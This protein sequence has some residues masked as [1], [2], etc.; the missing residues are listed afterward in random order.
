MK[1]KVSKL[2]PYAERLQEWFLG[3]KTLVEAQG[4]LGADGCSVSLGRL[5]EW[6]SSRQSWIQGEQLIQQITSGANQ[7]REVEAA[8]GAHPAPE[9]ETVIKL[10]R[11]LAMQFATRANVD[12]KMMEQAERATKM[13]LEFAKLLEKRRVTDLDERRVKLLEQK[14]ALADAATGVMGDKALSEEQRAARMR[15]LFGMCG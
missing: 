9:L 7:C 5:S 12:P 3:G 10:H 6:W 14:S 13:V 8:F 15:E 11:V 1:A 2:D 4:L